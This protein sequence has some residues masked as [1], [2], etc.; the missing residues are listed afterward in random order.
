MNE[1]YYRRKKS[2]AEC[3]GMLLAGRFCSLREKTQQS[4][5]KWKKSP[6]TG[7]KEKD[8]IKLQEVES[9]HL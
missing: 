3:S 8:T 5:C 7:K 6:T 9:Y 1:R 2:T 4:D